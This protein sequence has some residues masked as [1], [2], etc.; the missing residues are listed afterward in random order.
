MSS[1]HQA[2]AAG[3]KDAQ[4]YDAYRPSYPAE[5]VDK[6]LKRLGIAD[7]AHANIVE[8]AAGTGKFTELLAR[9]HEGYDVIAVEPHGPMR[10]Q[11]VAKHLEGVKVFDGLAAKLPV[12]DEWGDACIAAQVSWPFKI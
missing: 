3:F 2:A 7:D 11:L 8:I 5:A 6:F 4:A 9:R 1:L 12:E 10:E